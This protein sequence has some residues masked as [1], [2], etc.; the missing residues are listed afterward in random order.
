MANMVVCL[1]ETYFFNE[2]D[3]FPK[4]KGFFSSPKPILVEAGTKVEALVDFLETYLQMETSVIAD[5]DE[6]MNDSAAVM[7]K[8]IKNGCDF[9]VI[10]RD[11][12]A[13]SLVPESLRNCIILTLQESKG[14]EFE[15]VL[16]F[17]H[18]TNNDAERGWRYIYSR[19]SISERPLASTEKADYEVDFD[20]YR[21][22]KLEFQKLVK[23]GQDIVY[24]FST[25]AQLDQMGTQAQLEGLSADMK[26]L[27]V[28]ITR[29]KK[30]LIIYDY[31]ESLTSGFP[32]ADFDKW[33]TKLGLVDIM[34]TSN[35]DKF[36]G[37]YTVDPNWR[38]TQQT[39]ARE[40]GYFFLKSCEYGSAERFFKVSND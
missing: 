28:A 8:K 32:R 38:S 15:N 34:N 11:E 10:V 16:L 6:S 37:L 25:N 35:I 13:K 33:C 24:Q 20:M 1:L 4:E 21:R 31:C 9:C 3:S 7:S 17:N 39:I 2:I 40:K 19:T 14:L 5:A 12:N 27:Y 26:F 30:N 36:K 29:A 23:E 22:S 18:F